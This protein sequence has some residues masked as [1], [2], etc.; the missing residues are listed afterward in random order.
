MSA[1]PA[2]FGIHDNRRLVQ[3]SR[4]GRPSASRS[5]SAPS[6]SEYVFRMCGAQEYTGE[7]QF[8]QKAC[9]RRAPLSAT[10]MYSRGLPVRTR[11][12]SAGAAMLARKAEPVSI[13]QSRQWQTLTVPGSTSASYA[14]LPAVASPLHFHLNGSVVS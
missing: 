9:T 12:R 11:K 8:A 10:L 5:L 1:A 7:P 14:D 4:A 2:S 13:W 6:R 3:I